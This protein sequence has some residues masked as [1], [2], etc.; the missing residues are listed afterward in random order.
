MTGSTTREVYKEAKRATV[1]G[2]SYSR[3][4]LGTWLIS[5]KPLFF[6]ASPVTTAARVLGELFSW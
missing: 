5:N 4:D 3:E 2:L 6:T 1:S